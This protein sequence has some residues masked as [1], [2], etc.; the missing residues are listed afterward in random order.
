MVWS[1]DDSSLLAESTLPSPA[2][3]LIFSDSGDRL[4]AQTIDRLLVLDGS[5]LQQIGNSL[6]MLL[7][8]TQAITA[9]RAPPISMA[10]HLHTGT[11]SCSTYCQTRTV[12]VVSAANGLLAVSG[13]VIRLGISVRRFLQPG[14][15]RRRLWTG[16][17]RL[18][19]ICCFHPD[20]GLV[21]WGCL[22]THELCC[23]FEILTVSGCDCAAL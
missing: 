22:R 2:R 5:S 4:F 12:Y 9:K 11:G 13:D 3:Q 10:Q 23:A 16:D 19:M 8:F 7:H 1:T 15:R 21:F 14:Y 18:K 20:G 17:L 6:A